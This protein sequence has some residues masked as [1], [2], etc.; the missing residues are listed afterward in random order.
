[1]PAATPTRS[2]AFPTVTRPGV[3]TI[4]INPHFT[5]AAARQAEVGEALLGQWEREPLPEGFVSW[6]VFASTD[7]EALLAY[8]QWVNDESRRRCGVRRPETEGVWAAEPVYYRVYRSLDGSDGSEEPGCL[9]TATFDTDGPERQRY[10][11]D[12]LIAAQPSDARTPGALGAHFHLSTDGTRV[13]LYSLWTSQRAHAEAAEAGA[14]DSGHGIFTETPGVRPTYG[15]CY[16]LLGSL[17][18]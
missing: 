2:L 18:R 10:F 16:S 11:V 17:V 15:R 9:I 7:G 5:G 4:E 6:S 12:A 3:G 14:H 1:M 13:L 8:G